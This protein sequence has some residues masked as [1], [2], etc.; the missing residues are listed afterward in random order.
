HVQRVSD[1]VVGFNLRPVLTLFL[2]YGSSKGIVRFLIRFRISVR[3]LESGSSSL[4][5]L[6]HVSFLRYLIEV[7]GQESS[8]IVNQWLEWESTELQV[9][10]SDKSSAMIL[11]AIRPPESRPCQAALL[12]DTLLA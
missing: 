6:I 1:G 3:L 12:L 2:L 4:Y 8:D 9:R 7:N 5:L 11:R 10:M